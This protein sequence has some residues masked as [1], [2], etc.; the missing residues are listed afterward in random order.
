MTLYFSAE[1]SNDVWESFRA[2]VYT[3]V[4]VT[5][6]YPH[7]VNADWFNDS[8]PEIEGLPAAVRAAFP[9]ATHQ[10]IFSGCNCRHVQSKANLQRQLGRMEDGLWAEKANEI[11]AL[12]DYDDT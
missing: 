5:L 3:A 4:E 10:P 9:G 6:G 7:R 1:E 11:Q 12:A 8:D 2:A